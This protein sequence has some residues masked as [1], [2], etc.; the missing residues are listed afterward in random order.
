MEVD[1]GKNCNDCKEFEHITK[2]YKNQRFI[3]QERR[4]EY[5]DNHNMDNLKEEKNLVVLY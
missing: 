4:I 5:G 2:Y 1:R 3:A